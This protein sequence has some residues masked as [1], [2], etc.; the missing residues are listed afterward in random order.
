MKAVAE[1]DGNTESAVVPKVVEIEATVVRVLVHSI[2]ANGP[3]RDFGTVP[4]PQAGVR[5]LTLVNS[6]AGSSGKVE[7]TKFYNSIDQQSTISDG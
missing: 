7:F 3:L 2:N 5:R 4:R 6:S 1:I